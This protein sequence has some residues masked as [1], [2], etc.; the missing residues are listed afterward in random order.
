VTL[1]GIVSLGTVTPAATAS[2][3]ADA[4][5]P[6]RFTIKNHGQPNANRGANV[7]L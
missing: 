7:A 3:A 5:S 1:Q 2:I 4:T 6:L